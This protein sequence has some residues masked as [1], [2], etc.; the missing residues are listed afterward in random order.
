M[1]T[2]HPR[3]TL[4]SPTPNG[5]RST[6][7][8]DDAAVRAA[9]ASRVDEVCAAVGTLLARALG[10]ARVTVV[11]EDEFASRRARATL[12]ADVTGRGMR[13]PIRYGSHRLGHI[14]LVAESPHAIGAQ[15]RSLAERTAALVGMA[16]GQRAALA[17]LAHAL[18][19]PLV[20]VKSFIALLPEA[21]HEREYLTAFRAVALGELG[22]L[23]A[24]IDQALAWAVPP[25]ER[26]S[27]TDLDALVDATVQLLAPVARAQ[28]VT[29]RHRRADRA[30][31][32]RVAPRSIRRALANLVLNAIEASAAGS[33]VD[34]VVHA[35]RARGRR[36]W[37]VTVENA[38]QAAERTFVPFASTKPRP[39]GL[40]L[41][42]ASRVAQ[43]HGGRL[44]QTTRPGGIAFALHLPAAP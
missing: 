27:A 14:A 44:A 1:Q 18:R 3:V 37:V 12:G 39:G 38:G 21:L 31:R 28:R 30:P 15:E 43:H 19:N 6:D 22:R 10:L 42:I 35:E 33:D 34:V 32:V 4:A 29:L 24:E 40:G 2:T 8:A 13:V 20:A 17:E 25:R 26:R 41:P 16:L 23:E 7:R 5:G 9:P 36:W 11:A